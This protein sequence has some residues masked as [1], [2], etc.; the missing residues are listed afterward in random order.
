M[1]KEGLVGNLGNNLTPLAN[2]DAL[3]R[4][5]TLM[6]AISPATAIENTAGEGVDNSDTTLVTTGTTDD[7]VILIKGKQLLGLDSVRHIW[8]PGTRS[9]RGRL[10]ETRNS[11]RILTI[12]VALL[13]QN[14]ILILLINLI[15]Q[16]L[17][18]S[19]G[20]GIGNLVL[21]GRS[22]NL[23]G[24]DEWRPSLVNENGIGLINNAEA[25]ELARSGT[26]CGE[27]GLLRAE[28]QMITQVIKT[29]LGIGNVH[30]VARICLATFRL[31]HTALD[32][33]NTKAEE[34]MDLAHLFHITTSEVVVSGDNERRL[35]GERVDVA[36]KRRNEGLALTGIHFGQ[37]SAVQDETTKKLDI[38]VA[39]LQDSPVINAIEGGIIN[40]SKNGEKTEGLKIEIP[41]QRCIKARK[42]KHIILALMG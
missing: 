3:L 6:Q 27:D 33:A 30:H 38:V 10:K 18:Q 4:L 19:V 2:V 16:S 26:R 22:W 7:G 32:Q 20:Q 15:V 39:L 11:E 1:T 37:A 36:G 41:C 13:I 23:L 28:S 24:N 8:S 35:A 17:L 42:F 5:D 40:E 31:R 21:I 9:I 29:K 25:L 34:A 14:N 12:L